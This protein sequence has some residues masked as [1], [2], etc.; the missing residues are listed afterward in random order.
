MDRGRTVGFAVLL[1]LSLVLLWAAVTG[2][3]ADLSASVI[4]PALLT[5]EGT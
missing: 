3:F 2:R 5:T 4:S 1:M